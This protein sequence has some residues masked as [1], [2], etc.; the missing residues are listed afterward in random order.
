MI[1]LEI[2]EQQL[3]DIAEAIDEPATTEKVNTFLLS[4]NIKLPKSIY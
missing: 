4:F 1:R 2:T 3:V